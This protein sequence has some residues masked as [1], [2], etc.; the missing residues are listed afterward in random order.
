MLACSP[1]ISHDIT[2]RSCSAVPSPHLRFFA[3]WNLFQTIFGNSHH[4]RPP[5]G[6]ILC[7]VRRP[8]PT[9]SGN[10]PGPLRLPLGLICSKNTFCQVK[11]IDSAVWRGESQNIENWTAR[12]SKSFASRLRNLLLAPVFPNIKESFSFCFSTEFAS[13]QNLLIYTV[14]PRRGSINIIKFH[15]HWQSVLDWLR[16]GVAVTMATVLRS[17]LP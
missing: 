3:C 7:S 2:W 14:V 16:V 9:P 6:A 8:V 11:S 13:R 17:A 12:S 15:H 1:A 4:Q 10:F 5:V